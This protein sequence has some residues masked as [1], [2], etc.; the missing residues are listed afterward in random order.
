[1]IKESWFIKLLKKIGFIKTYSISKSVMCKNAK[2][3]CN[4]DCD[5]CAW[6]ED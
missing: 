4:N 3:I 5:N 6:K 1:M 2:N